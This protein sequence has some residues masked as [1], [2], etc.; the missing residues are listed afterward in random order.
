MNHKYNGGMTYSHR[1]ERESGA[2][3]GLQVA[4]IGLG[5][6]VLGLGS[7]SIWS[8]VAY[9]EAQSDVDD[10]I[11][12]AV[13]AAREEKGE[14]DEAKFAEREKQPTKTFKA[15]D[16]YC[17]LTFQYPKTWSQYWSEQISNGS[18]F[19][20]YLNPDI[21]PPITSSQQYAL[22]VVIE[23]KDY[24]DVVGQY[25]NLVAKG[26]LKS[27]TTSSEGNQGTRLTGNFSRN[28]R[29][30]AVIYRCRDKTITIQTDADTF[31]SDFQSIIGTIDYNA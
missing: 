21:V 6:L 19:R 20:A 10:K 22:R 30:D 11:A 14:E 18:D 9:S 29:G 7:F 27:S 26:D 15:P 25:E 8:F 17:G 12:V 1:Y 13:A 2:I 16:D 5:V 31:K 24:D 23:Q 4:V 28:I 3:S